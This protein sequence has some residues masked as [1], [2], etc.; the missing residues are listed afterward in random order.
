MNIDEAIKH[1]REVADKNRLANRKDIEHQ[2]CEECA[3]EHE[4]LAEWLEELKSYQ[5]ISAINVKELQKSV[6]VRK[7]VTEIVNR[8]LI[9]GKNNYKEVYDCFH[10]IAKV[11]QDNY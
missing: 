3:K 10:E 6:N 5:I 7:Q 1:A 4:Q 11:V 9:A 2:N 8:Q